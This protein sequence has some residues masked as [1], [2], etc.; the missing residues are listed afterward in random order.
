M[1]W[2]K[3]WL[4]GQLDRP[5]SPSTETQSIH[6]HLLS[7]SRSSVTPWGLSKAAEFQQWQCLGGGFLSHSNSEHHGVR[8]QLRPQVWGPESGCLCRQRLISDC[9]QRWSVIVI[10]PR[11]RPPGCKWTLCVFLVKKNQHLSTMLSVT[12]G[13]SSVLLMIRHVIAKTAHTISVL[14]K[15]SCSIYLSVQPVA[16]KGIFTVLL[17]K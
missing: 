7:C 16:K 6:P 14:K 1:L 4:D 12:K 8:H 11:D 17:G 5:T 3:S 9:W 13:T 15:T 10:L 2:L